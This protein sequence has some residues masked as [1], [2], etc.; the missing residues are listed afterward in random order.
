MRS[1]VRSKPSRS[2]S[3]PRRTSS[4]RNNS[5][6]VAEVSVNCSSSFFTLAPMGRGFP[7]SCTSE[8]SCADLPAAG[9]FEGIEHGLFHAHFFDLGVAESLLQQ[10]VQDHAYIFRGR[11]GCLELSQRVQVLVIKPLQD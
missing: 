4:S 10:V 8:P 6:V 7:P 2:G 9:I 5:S 3:S 1:G 11:H